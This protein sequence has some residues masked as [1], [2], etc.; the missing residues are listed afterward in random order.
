[1]NCEQ[2]RDMLS[3]Y[4]DDTLALGE[5]AQSTFELKAAIIAHLEDCAQCRVV[6]ADYRRFDSLLRQLPRVH[7]TSSLRESIFSSPEYLELTGTGPY[8]PSR[9][10]GNAETVPYRRVRKHG[11]SGSHPH[12]VALPGGRSSRSTL[13]TNP[14]L[15]TS[16]KTRLRQVVPLPEH[17]RSRSQ[18]GP[19]RGLQI[20]RIVIAAVVLLTL[21]V[22]SMIGYHLLARQPAISQTSHA[23]LPPAGLPARIPL[24]QGMHYVYLSNGALW[25]SSTNGSAQIQQMT[26]KDVIVAAHWVVTSPLPGRYAG[27]ML[28]YIDLLHARVHTIRSDSLSDTVIGQP[29]LPANV[30]PSSLWDTATGSAILHSLTWSADGSMLAFVADPNGTGQTRPLHLFDLDGNCATCRPANAG[31]RFTPGLVP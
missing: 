20:M 2:V 4:L 14:K 16:R 30:A 6:L 26:P 21:G 8:V 3:A 15:S 10:N 17:A 28:A 12:L 5:A 7:P 11:E 23:I 25:S 13:P 1:M 22:G 31:Q 19:M 29:L 9:R 27:D 24:T 18:R